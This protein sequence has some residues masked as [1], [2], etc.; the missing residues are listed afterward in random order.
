MRVILISYY[1]PP[2]RAVGALRPSKVARALRDAGHDVVVI[3][4][5]L[6][7]EP[8]EATDPSGVTVRRVRPIPNPREAWLA[9]KRRRHAPAA[10]APGSADPSTVGGAAAAPR[11]AAWMRWLLALLWLPDDRQGFILPAV[12]AA[13]AERARGVDLLYTTAPPFSVHLAGLV[14]ARLLGLRWAAEFRDPWTDN[15]WKPPHVRSRFSDAVERWLERR[16]LRRA[17]VLVSVSEGIDAVL[18]PKRAAQARTQHVVARNGIDALQPARA[19]QPSGRLRI[20]HVG[21]FYHRRDPRPFLE[22]L[23]LVRQQLALHGLPPDVVFAGDCRW[24]NDVSVE[25]YVRGLGL[26]D[27]VA[28]EDW[29]PHPRSLELVRDADLLLLLA[30]DQ[31]AQ[32]PNKLYEYLGARRPILA[33]ADAGGETARL[34]EQLHGHYVVTDG[35]VEAAAAALRAVAAGRDATHAVLAQDDARLSE[36]TTARQLGRLVDALAR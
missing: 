27:A 35:R 10:G 2:D 5:R 1:Y 21:T 17:D 33:F 11:T 7:G 30:Q 16:C 29:V 32:L 22:A 25:A 19:R 36:W 9:L 26:D 18:A 28:F 13:L 34:L 14:L 4:A 3:A 12:R 24:F 15:P 23:A 31:P 6:P 20:V 8:E